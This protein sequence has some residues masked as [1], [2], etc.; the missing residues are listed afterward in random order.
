MTQNIQTNGA[1]WFIAG[2]TINAVYVIS[3]IHSLTGINIDEITFSEAA[4][5][6]AYLM[7]PVRYTG[8]VVQGTN[9]I[10]NPLEENLELFFIVIILMDA[11]S[12]T[13]MCKC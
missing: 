8:K 6:S 4:R 1:Q 7:S 12:F 5:Q 13:A 11:S 9:D 3:P 2:P 10:F